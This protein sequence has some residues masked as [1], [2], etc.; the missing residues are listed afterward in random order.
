[1]F[2]SVECLLVAAGNFDENSLANLCRRKVAAAKTET[3]TH[4]ACLFLCVLF[5]KNTHTHFVFI[6]LLERIV[7]K[8]ITT[9]LVASAIALVSAAA[10]GPWSQTVQ[11]TYDVG[12]AG[13][14][15]N[16]GQW[17]CFCAGDICSLVSLTVFFP[18]REFF[19]TFF[20][21]RAWRSA[22]HASVPLARI[23]RIVPTLGYVLSM[24]FAVLV[25]MLQR[26]H[27]KRSATHA[28]FNLR[29]P[30]NPAARLTPPGKK[31]PYND[32]DD[33]DAIDGSL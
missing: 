1:M 7:P 31:Y 14:Q 13:A 16:G 20:H 5:K 2:V 22:A 25:A 26:C 17:H 23:C 30:K 21:H 12:Q 27:S 8:M 19:P 3:T 4:L 32:D 29:P 24:L 28:M 9:L 6:D 18:T 15:Y 10:P 33:D 11:I